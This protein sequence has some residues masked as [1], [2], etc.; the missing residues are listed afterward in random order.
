MIIDRINIDNIDNLLSI[1]F[2]DYY[3]MVM[4]DYYYYMMIDNEVY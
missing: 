3:Y 4:I 1:Y 2:I